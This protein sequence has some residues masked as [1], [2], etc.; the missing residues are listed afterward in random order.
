MTPIS[1]KAVG[2]IC[3]KARETRAVSSF[4]PTSPVR[5]RLDK[6]DFKSLVSTNFTTLA[7]TAFYPVN[8]IGDG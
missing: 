2:T 7:M 8:A 5:K 6:G 4:S 3:M 1:Q